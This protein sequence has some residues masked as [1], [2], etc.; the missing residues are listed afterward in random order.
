M[1]HS[2]LVNKSTHSNK[3]YSLNYLDMDSESNITLC[4][5]VLLIAGCS[6]YTTQPSGCPIP[7]SDLMAAPVALMRI[8]GDPDRAPAVMKHNADALLD[9]RY[10]LIRWQKWYSASNKK[11]P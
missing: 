7:P 10:K 11:A 8:G 5:T 2:Y 6:S 1:L 3:D 9:D 4:A